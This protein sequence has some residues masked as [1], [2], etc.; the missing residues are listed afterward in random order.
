MPKQLKEI[1]NFNT[2]VMLNVSERDSHPDTPAYSL[3]INPDTEEGLL[4]GIETNRF[5]FSLQN[6]IRFVSGAPW[7]LQQGLYHTDSYNK[8]GIIVNDIS[9]FEDSDVSFVYATGEKGIKEKL[10]VRYAE[11]IWELKELSNSTVNPDSSVGNTGNIEYIPGAT[12]AIG[13]TVLTYT[14]DDVEIT[15][16]SDDAHLTTDGFTEGV[17]TITIKTDTKGDLDGEIITVKTPD[18]KTVVYEWDDSGSI[19]TG[20]VISSTRCC[21]DISSATTHDHMATQLELALASNIDSDSG[22][23][24]S[25]G[26]G[27]RLECD[28]DTSGA[29][30]IVTITQTQTTL[31]HLCPIDSYFVFRPTGVTFKGRTGSEILK[32]TE[33]N[34]TDKTITVKRGCFG[35]AQY[36]LTGAA[37]YDLWTPAYKIGGEY[38]R[39]THGTV[40]LLS[41]SNYSGNNIGSNITYEMGGQTHGTTEKKFLG[42]FE[43]SSAVFNKND[44]SLVLGDAV[45]PGYINE[46]DKITIYYG[47]DDSINSTRT[48]TIN[49]ISSN[50]TTLTL[51]EA[52]DDHSSGTTDIFIEKGIIKNPVFHHQNDIYNSYDVGASEDYKFAHWWNKEYTYITSTGGEP[53]YNVT[54]QYELSTNTNVAATTGGVTDEVGSVLGRGE[55][56]AAKFYPFQSTK[57]CARLTAKFERLQQAGTT[58]TLSASDTIIVGTYEQ[59]VSKGDVLKIESEYLLV[60]S[61]TDSETRVQRGYLNTAAVSHSGGSSI[62]YKNINPTIG[63]TISKNDLKSGQNYKLSFYAKTDTSGVGAL[64]IMINGGYINKNGKWVKYS[65]DMKMGVRSTIAFTAMQEDRWIQFEDLNKTYNDTALDSNGEEVAID[66]TFRKFE[67]DIRL[68]KEDAI[69]TDM[70]IEFVSKGIADST[71]L[72]DMVTMIEDAPVLLVG[73][74]SIITAASYINKSGLRDLVVYDSYMNKL[75]V[76][77]NFTEDAITFTDSQINFSKYTDGISS[78]SNNR[79]TLIPRNREIHA[80]F[81]SEAGDSNP[82]WLGYLNHNVFGQNV[83]DTLYQDEDT[84]HKYAE[85]GGSSVSKLC[86]AGEF[87]YISAVWNGSDSLTVTMPGTALHRQNVGDNIIVRQWGDKANN[88]DGAG[89]WFVHTRTSDVE[90]IAKRKTSIAE[91]DAWE[92]DNNPT[93]HPGGIDDSGFKS[94]ICFR[95]YYYYGIREGDSTILRISPEARISSVS[96]TDSDYPAGTTESSFNI[97]SSIASVSTCYNK[98]SDGSQGGYIYALDGSAIEESELFVNVIDVCKAWDSWRT[99]ELTT[100]KL[101]MNTVPFHWANYAN[102]DGNE[103][104]DGEVGYGVTVT[105]RKASSRCPVIKYS[106]KPSDI[107]E[108]KGPTRS[109]LH[110]AVNPGQNTPGVF[111]TRL[112]VQMRP[113]TGATFTEGNRFLFCARTDSTCI[114][115]SKRINGADRSPCTTLTHIKKNYTYE[116]GQDFGSDTHK[117][118]MPSGHDDDNKHHV[119]TSNWSSSWS[120]NSIRKYWLMYE[121]GVTKDTNSIQHS[122]QWKGRIHLTGDNLGW[123][124]EDKTF[125][126]GVSISV[127]RYG[128]FGIADNDGDGVLD[129]TGVVVPSQESLPLQSGSNFYYGAYGHEGTRVSAHAVGLL[130]SGNGNKWL[131]RGG[132]WQSEYGSDDDSDAYMRMSR[133]KESEEMYIN[134]CIFVCTDVHW[135][136]KRDGTEDGVPSITNL[137]GGS[138]VGTRIWD[139]ASFIGTRKQHFS[140][141]DAAAARDANTGWAADD[142]DADGDGDSGISDGAANAWQGNFNCAIF[143]AVSGSGIYTD[144]SAGND[145]GLGDDGGDED[146]NPDTYTISWKQ[147]IHANPGHHPHYYWDKED[148]LNP[149]IYTNIEKDEGVA[150]T[151]PGAYS[152]SWWTAPNMMTDTTG[153][154]NNDDY[155]SLSD[156]GLSQVSSGDKV[157]YWPNWK[158][159]GFLLPKTGKVDRL[160]YRAGYLIRPLRD[161]IDVNWRSTTISAPIAPDTIYH[162]ENPSY[163]SALYVDGAIGAATEVPTNIDIQN[164][165]LGGVVPY[166]DVNDLKQWVLGQNIYKDDGTF[167]GYCTSVTDT[168]TIVVQMLETTLADEDRL[169]LGY[170]HYSRGSQVNG[171]A[172]KLWMGIADIDDVSGEY[173][174]TS[175][176]Y[177]FQINNQFPTTD[178]TDKTDEYR[179]SGTVDGKYSETYGYLSGYLYEPTNVYVEGGTIPNYSLGVYADHT[180]KYPVIRLHKTGIIG[181]AQGIIEDE[182]G[183]VGGVPYQQ[184]ILGKGYGDTNRFVGNMITVVDKDTGHMQTRYIVGSEYNATDNSLYISVHYPL[185]HTPIGHNTYASADKFFIWSHAKACV[186]PLVKDIPWTLENFAFGDSDD[187]ADGTTFETYKNSVPEAQNPLTLQVS[188]PTIMSTFGGLDLRRVRKSNVNEAADSGDNMTLTLTPADHSKFAVD[189]IVSFSTANDAVNTGNFTVTTAAD[190]GDDLVMVNADATNDTTVHQK[191]TTNQWELVVADKGGDGILAELRQLLNSGYAQGITGFDTTPTFGNINRSDYATAVVHATDKPFIKGTS[192]SAITITAGS[193][194]GDEDYFLKQND[195]RFKLSLVYDGYQEGPLSSNYWIYSHA[196]TAG[197]LDITILVKEY[198]HRLTSVN[199]YR[200]DNA[201]SFYRLIKSITTKKGWTY[202]SDTDSYMFSFRD[203]GSAFGTYESRTGMN[204]TI[205]NITVK[206]GLS[207]ELD[208][209]LFVGD[210]AHNDIK[211]A[212]NQIFRSRPGKY[213]I[214]DWT[215]DYI[216]LK[217]RPVAMAAFNGR[218]YVFDESNT[219]RINPHTLQIEDTF[220][221]VGCL[222]ADSLIVTEFGMFFGDKNGAYMH[223]GQNAVQIS[224]P[225]YKGGD[226]DLTWDSKTQIHDVSWYGLLTTHGLDKLKVTFDASTTTVLFLV[227]GNIY[228][229]ARDEKILRNYIWAYSIEGQRWDLWELDDE[230]EIGKPFVGIK[231]GVFIPLGDSFYEF[232]K[233]PNKKYYS[234]LSKKLTLGEDSIMKV[235]NKIK[236]NGLNDNLQS[237]GDYSE[238]SNRLLIQTS[239]GAISSSSITYTEKTNDSEYKIKGTNKK[240]RWVQLLIENVNKPIDS[241]GIIYRR[242]T[243]K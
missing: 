90:F 69:D 138:L 137:Q 19:Q 122:H 202:V 86:V 179:Y 204:E 13:D 218:L 192:E 143:G 20:E 158:N 161:E 17:G 94:K 111:D 243:T 31:N 47:G 37:V 100:V 81:G 25:I 215:R 99:D 102:M 230:T 242:K 130:G 191:L 163:P 173:L 68:P 154:R 232:R 10:A 33:I 225:I 38:V 212:S 112:W 160:N 168:N 123:L 171:N 147:D 14:G 129:G 213:S 166:A 49:K 118:S 108:T 220:E 226:T 21:I 42:Y 198:S 150:I 217:S 124:S 136:D 7:G 41:W 18:G 228:D 44:K 170:S 178:F 209:Y 1:K 184:T 181:G 221:G 194:G 146:D 126:E 40:G 175:K 59:S 12:F 188:D 203:D 54:N 231:G 61:V 211:N 113:T 128:L 153:V 85:G 58:T 144:S 70:D 2:G 152:P 140:I 45:T 34:T 114:T 235:Y 132:G 125:T 67:L 117:F 156:D 172:Y 66:T 183:H 116:A 73:V 185:G 36:A 53:A 207:T 214:F 87:E 149:D 23:G 177:S 72:I 104:G 95:P 187:A 98:S 51:D 63:Q 76:N 222:N 43:N 64:S 134:N 159:D 93:A 8:Q 157:P 97:G 50:S 176:M 80:G 223:N 74:E 60:T 15:D 88:W 48:F 229:E 106:G 186:A 133:G 190:G 233:G 196:D 227:S 75:K 105:P 24:A 92:I 234:W 200:R 27:H 78:S 26:H 101:T 71:I 167:V 197:Y 65:N 107:L 164:S 145:D 239:E 131:N 195:Y 142:S 46:G 89:V 56:K 210:C 55:N 155:S 219:Y 174:R 165:G 241:L 91:A 3:N 52:P 141:G 162:V 182:S 16:T 79:A 5:V 120:E 4:D 35:T 216:V 11:P 151:N 39:T 119:Y 199:I 103:R 139:G 169:H 29:D 115:S 62:L 28:I 127:A 237:E 9:V 148:A 180:T 189:D 30:A 238:S 121:D 208:G 240:G 109:Y 77:K 57:A 83:S 206:Y 96:A 135:G 201:E 22:G 110:K 84:V 82:Q 224:K 6:D 205:N 236:V 193:V 32:T